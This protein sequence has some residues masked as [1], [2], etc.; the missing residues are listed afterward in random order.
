MQKW[1]IYEME[2]VESELTPNRD[3][4]ITIYEYGNWIKYRVIPVGNSGIP[5]TTNV[6]PP[7][8]I[9]DVDGKLPRVQIDTREDKTYEVVLEE[10][11]KEWNVND[12]QFDSSHLSVKFG[13]KKKVKKYGGWIR[14]KVI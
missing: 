13:P 6:N 9:I 12:L 10:V 4:Y 2:F 11:K 14:L 1:D 5:A 8:Y 7:M 3:R